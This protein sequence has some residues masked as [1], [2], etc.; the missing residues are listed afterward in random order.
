MSSSTLK[1]PRM[2]RID[3]IDL[4]YSCAICHQTLEEI[5]NNNENE[6]GLKDGRQ[7]DD[8]PRPTA[9]CPVCAEGIYDNAPKSL[10]SVRG[11]DRKSHDPALPDSFFVVPP[12]SLDKDG[13]DMDALKFQFTSLVRTGIANTKQL[14][15]ERSG[16]ADAE[17][18]LAKSEKT[19]A[20]LQAVIRDKEQHIKQLEVSQEKLQKW[21]GQ[22]PKLIKYINLIPAMEHEITVL[23]QCLQEL[24]YKP[25]DRQYKLEIAK[26][27]L[28]LGDQRD[29]I[30]KALDD[31]SAENAEQ[32]K[33]KDRT[34]EDSHDELP[35][36][37]RKRKRDSEKHE[38]IQVRLNNELARPNPMP[39]PGIPASRS[40]QRSPQRLVQS[41]NTP[42]EPVTESGRLDLKFPP[43]DRS[44]GNQMLS[45]FDA[46]V[47]R[48][49]P[50][51]NVQ[52]DAG[53]QASLYESPIDNLDQNY[54]H[55]RGRLP[56]SN[57]RHPELA[58]SDHLDLPA[59]SLMDQYGY[60]NQSPVRQ[61][62]GESVQQPFPKQQQQFEGQ[63]PPL[64]DG[65][66]VDVRT[67]YT[68]TPSP[69]KVPLGRQATAMSVA[70]P[71][72]KKPTIPAYRDSP[73]SRGFRKP[74]SMEP[75]YPTR[76]STGQSPVQYQRQKTTNGLSFMHEPEPITNGSAYPNYGGP[77]NTIAQ[78]RPRG[79]EHGVPYQHG[80]RNHGPPPQTPRRHDV[81]SVPSLPSVQPSLHVPY[82]TPSQSR[83]SMDQQNL[84]T[85]RG[86]KAGGF[87][88][89]TPLPVRPTPMITK[90]HNIWSS[91]SGR[92][93]MR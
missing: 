72:F 35:S 58:A 42:Q 86:V 18:R 38:P 54:Y 67:A 13:P 9:I 12:K 92:R 70:S 4:I 78:M 6:N 64:Q 79:F 2:P 89:Q 21:E 82:T 59:Q 85:I 47:P 51:K 28:Q 19:V 63:R 14:H 41:R 84:G 61:A 74:A 17:L 26:Q 91:G 15:V 23:R 10:Y 8:H 53:V 62:R 37:E 1:D 16:R 66:S 31:L 43:N 34:K 29:P 90:A 32:V 71:F 24:G 49:S 46:A 55:D 48:F 40:P 60:Q 93:A 39:P 30:Q 80:H 69:R 36:Q 27:E 11:F 65:R 87:S 68:A 52:H 56:Y 50:Q 20:A 33:E 7:E 73:Q 75:N 77:G 88:M 76:I 81:G 5:Y 83:H 45:S 22:K 25:P 3:A 57:G 44:H